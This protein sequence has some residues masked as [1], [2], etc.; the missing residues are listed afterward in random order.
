MPNK[1]RSIV[2]KNFDVS[3]S[4]S[5][6]DRAFARR[7]ARAAKK[8]SIRVFLDEWYQSYL[9]GKKESVYHEV[10]GPKTHAVIPI[11]SENYVDC[12]NARFELDI[13]LR[14]EKKRK[15]EFIL[16]IRLDNTIVAGIQGTKAFLSANDHSPAKIA[17]LL[18]EKLDEIV[19]EASVSQEQLLLPQSSDQRQIL[20][21]IVTAAIPN[22]PELYEKLYPSLPWKTELPRLQASGLITINETISPTQEAIAAFP[23]TSDE[24]QFLEDK[25]ITSLSEISNHIDIAPYTALHFVRRKRFD[26]AVQIIAHAVMGAD[27]SDL[28]YWNSVYL[29]ILYSMFDRYF[30]SVSL[31]SQFLL[32]NSLG[33]CLTSAR[34]FDGAIEM[35]RKTHA[36]AKKHGSTAWIGQSLINSGVALFEAG[37]RN[38]A[39]KR[40]ELARTHAEKNKDWVLL[41]SALGNLA[42]CIR[43]H[44]TGTARKLLAE[45][46]KAKRRS[47]DV[48]GIAANLLQQGNI[49][50]DSGQV[51]KGLKFYELASKE[52]E[53]N[54]FYY[55][56]ALAVNNVGNAHRNLGEQAK[57]IKHFQLSR[58]LASKNGF[59]YPRMLALQGLGTT[60]FEVGKYREAKEVFVELLEVSQRQSDI[61]S[62]MTCLHAIAV[63]GGLLDGPK[64]ATVHFDQAEKF[65]L[66]QGLGD[67]FARCVVDRTRKFEDGPTGLADIPTIEKK[68][69][70][71]ARTNKHLF[72]GRLWRELARV[73][74]FR[75]DNAN[76]TKRYYEQAISCLNLVEKIDEEV[77]E[78]YFEFADW[79]WIAVSF[80]E[81]IEVLASANELAKE[82]GF[83]LQQSIAADKAGVYLQNMDRFSEA[84]KM[85]AIAIKI[86]RRNKFTTLLEGYLNNQG[87]CFRKMGR[88]PESESTFLEAEQLAA[89]RNPEAAIS[90]MHN[91]AVLRQ[92]QERFDEA[93]ELL[94][95]CK[96][97]CQTSEYWEELIRAWE[98]LAHVAQQ[99]G[100]TRLSLQ[101]Y[102][103]ALQIAKSKR[104]G[105]SA[106]RTALNFASLLY[107]LD[108]PKKALSILLPYASDSTDP[109]LSHLIA[110]TLGQCYLAIGKSERSLSYLEQATS[111]SMSIGDIDHHLDAA[112][113]YAVSL[114][115]NGRWEEAAKRMQSVESLEKDPELWSALMTQLLRV[116]LKMESADS[117]TTYDRIQKVA[118]R[119]NFYDLLASLHFTIGEHLWKGDRDDKLKALQAFAW[120]TVDAL[121]HDIVDPARTVNTKSEEEAAIAGDIFGEALII[122]TMPETATNLEEL[123]SLHLELESWAKKKIRQSDL[124]EFVLNLT[125]FAIELVPLNRSPSKM[126]KRFNELFQEWTN[127]NRVT[128]TWFPES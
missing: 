61:E 107:R 34:Q 96:R 98:A 51:R 99:Q 118:S 41:G 93:E 89:A 114:E 66:K 35:F 79:L 45:S 54:G 105:P 52:C 97:R 126:L 47:K 56:R 11:I 58:K 104:F 125:R 6:Y 88:W 15:A 67:W 116:Q 100:K 64:S 48:Q 12:D 127:N 4:F 46:L 90:I 24:Y 115:Q 31:E 76:N 87:E 26:E 21:L 68:A 63:C 7:I 120:A 27:G 53:K 57:A 72:A 119:N 1:S 91:R 44:D 14:E 25:W 28:G 39:V 86:A 73:S 78:W 10:Y 110:L 30:S 16:P 109:S 92:V 84:T 29:T 71:L 20:G 82:K 106:V 33:I 85:H 19:G 49:E 36:L 32:Q 3:L 95:T 128:E 38:E 13:A 17:K 94:E 8:L 43:Q 83:F 122:L 69:R 80:S 55:M 70:Q 40:Y 113:A 103:K 101:R 102:E 5:G 112:V 50:I 121:T 123:K 62:E 37:N 75:P 42:E 60:Y 65:A 81:A 18:R 77:L 108:A 9:W 74:R 111:L 2:H 117:Q 124:R 22:F 59:D 23:N